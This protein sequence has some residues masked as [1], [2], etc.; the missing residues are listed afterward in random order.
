MLYSVERTSLNSKLLSVEQIGAA[1][2]R[3]VSASTKIY[4]FPFFFFNRRLFF[5]DSKTLFSVSTS[6]LLFSNFTWETDCIASFL[7]KGG[8]VFVS[9]LI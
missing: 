8:M 9:S 4:N 1:V 5:L 6:F 7:F 2:N 3:F